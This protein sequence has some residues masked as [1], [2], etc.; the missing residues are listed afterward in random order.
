MSTVVDAEALRRLGD[1]LAGRA[2]VAEETFP[3]LLTALIRRAGSPGE[4]AFGLQILR[5]PDG[6]RA[7]SLIRTAVQVL[8]ER[9]VPFLL[10]WA[11]DRTDLTAGLALV[12]V[13]GHLGTPPAHGALTALE[14][15]SPNPVIRATAAACRKKLEDS[16]PVRYTLLPRL[17]AP[18]LTPPQARDLEHRLA[19]CG[20]PQLPALLTAH[21]DALGPLA[22][23]V[24]LGALGE[25]GGPEVAA[26]LDRRIDEAQAGGPLAPLL[27]RLCRARAAIQ[28]RLPDRESAAP[29]RWV[30][31]YRR[32]LQD[33]EV[34]SVC[35]RLATCT[36][37]PDL[38]E[39]YREFLQSP[40]DAVRLAGLDALAAAPGA[41]DEESV[42]R[43]L[44]GPS[45][46]EQ[47]AALVALKSM[48]QFRPL[49]EWGASVD[50]GR[51]RVAAQAALRAGEVGL[52]ARLAAD[53]EPAVAQGALDGLA[54][55]PA[56][57]RPSRAELEDVLHR[58]TVPLVFQEVCRAL[59]ADPTPETAQAFAGALGQEPWRRAA[60]LRALA[61]LHRI[62]AWSWA[63]LSGAHREALAEAIVEGLPGR[64]E[65]MLASLLVGDLDE[66]S[67]L[68]IRAALQ[69][70]LDWSRRSPGAP[71]PAPGGPEAVYMAVVGQLHAHEVRRKAAREVELALADPD[72]PANV[73]VQRVQTIARGWLRPDV[74]FDAEL[75]ARIEAYLVAVAVDRGAHTLA[76]RDAVAVLGQRGSL[77]VL[78]ALV[79]LR[80]N[81]TP[82]IAEAAAAAVETLAR[83]HPGANPGRSAGESGHDAPAVLLVEDEEKVRVL[84]ERF[85]FQKGF[86][87]FGAADG[88]AALELVGS[89]TVDLAVIDLQMPRL[90]GFGLLEALA[91]A[92]RRPR[93]L[94]VSSHTDRASVARCARLGVQD[95]LRKPVDLEELLRRVQRM[96]AR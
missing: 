46:V 86:Q 94:V 87:T 7:A 26:F 91:G 89:H 83:R 50:I 47:A 65:L 85:L 31:L 37:A 32:H 27:G 24:A 56:H 40:F 51:R 58:T 55:A 82:A 77:G 11:A 52:W 60:V 33:P 4:Q 93:I 44:S 13:M 15:R 68:R 38:A 23:P 34:A 71:A 21:W 84:Y 62:G 96:L 61:D 74:E 76:R 95:F 12:E 6:R 72:P 48:G 3:R 67:L 57:L 43:C 1:L 39:L 53:P 29:D 42:A 8:G 78:Q 64:D 19:A 73:R 79:Q 20:D 18:D 17:L 25:R 14:R 45:E 41:G 92:P 30:T 16:Q 69:S 36:P 81:P 75:S 2:Q 54:G 80:R 35:A 5:E 70:S 59:I 66:D 90:D 9:A 28:E 22:R 49:T 63:N 10:Q 88:L